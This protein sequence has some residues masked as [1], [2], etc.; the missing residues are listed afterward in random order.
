MHTLG[1]IGVGMVGGALQ[2]YFQS[3]GFP[4]FAYD[5]GKSLG[6]FEEVER[7]EFVFLCVPTDY[8]E[9]VG[10]DT[11]IIEENCARLREPKTI[12]IRSTVIPGTTDRLQKAF[13]QHALLVVPEFLTEATADEDT[14]N[15]ARVIIGYTKESRPH[16]EKI[17]SL[18]PEARFSKILPAREAEFVKYFS[19]TFY[20]TKVVFANQFYDVVERAG[21]NYDL[22]RECVEHDPMIAP[23]HV[24]VFHKGYRG[25]DGKCLPKD[26]QSFI[27]F[28]R[29]LGEP[30]RLLHIVTEIN[31]DLTQRKS[32]AAEPSLP[33]FL[34][35]RD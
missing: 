17:L 14:K 30:M 34:A 24:D 15:P 11:S 20:A 1:I 3:R 19:N 13:P 21:A 31:A 5:P 2:R 28:G 18:M 8:R 9:G 25:Y 32:A 29:S 6:S 35:A 4:V 23:S 7:A 10:C 26:T 16:A 33:S 12:I 22:I 27:H